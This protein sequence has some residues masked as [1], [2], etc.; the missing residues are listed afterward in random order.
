MQQNLTPEGLRLV[1]E[2]AARHGVGVD[3]ALGLLGA[4][5]QGHGAQAQFNHPDLGGMGQWSQ[6]GMIMIGDM[7]NS[8]L[9]YRVDALC[10][11]LAGLLRS[12]PFAAAPAQS[13]SQGDGASLFVSGTG[14]GGAW[15]PADLGA[16]A[17]TG[18]QNDM[19]YAWFPA[20]RRVAIEAGGEVRV[21]D[22]GEH[23]IS[24]FSQQQ[25]GDRSLT[26]TS[27]FGV[28]RLSDLAP[29]SPRSEAGQKSPPPSPTPPAPTPAAPTP[30]PAASTAARAATPAMEDIVKTIERLAEL[31]QKNIL[32]E[33][34]FAAKK[35]ELL[36]RL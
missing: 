18:A 36:S 21:Y 34:E 9:K 3:A 25:G 22:S 26:F 35:A 17:S 1:T 4:L 20:V 30:T 13:Q 28:V 8:G 24:G 7:F 5:A 6:G 27:Q 2:I 23:R 15:W 33:E 31:R 16:P 32:T 11:E 14:A 19:R 12:Q 29:V 10:N